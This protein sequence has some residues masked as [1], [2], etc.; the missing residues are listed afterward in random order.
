MCFEGTPG[1]IYGINQ[2]EAKTIVTTFDLLPKLKSFLNEVPNIKSV[3]Y[4]KNRNDVLNDTFPTN[5][6]LKSLEEVE[7]LGLENKSTLKFE[8]PSNRD[9]TAVIM[10]T[11]GT[12]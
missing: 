8:L 9:E 12:T 10:Y 1:L 2:T 5:I 11:S 4:I 3:V 6:C 7:E